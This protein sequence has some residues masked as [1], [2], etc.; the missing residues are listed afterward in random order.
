MSAFVGFHIAV[1]VIAVE[2]GMAWLLVSRDVDFPVWAM[3]L[4]WTAIGATVIA[5]AILL[6]GLIELVA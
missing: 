1:A 3:A 2:A 4:I 5:A 6:V